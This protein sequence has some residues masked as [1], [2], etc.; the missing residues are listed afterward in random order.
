LYAKI[1]AWR[2]FCAAVYVAFLFGLRLYGAP[3][4]IRVV[5]ALNP[6]LML[7]FV[8]NAHN[9]LLAIAVLVYAAAAMRRGNALGYAGSLAL[10]GVAGLIKLPYA[11]L[12]LPILAAIRPMWSRISGAAVMVAAVVGLSWLW[13]GAQYFSTLFGHVTARPEDVVHRIAGI[14]AL[15][16]L[17]TAFFG[18]RRLRT[19]VWIL[20]MLAASVFS[21]Y[22]AWGTPYALARRRVLGYLLICFP[23][24]TILFDSAFERFWELLAVLPIVV[25]ISM[26]APEKP[27]ARVV[28]A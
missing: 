15:L 18:R 10:I 22:F 13:G 9:D 3:E 12:G 27:A 8:A 17:A 11:V 21:W 14:V 26:F 16:V 24:V 1:M 2:V 25:L 6:G 20:P 7:Q 4:R 23:F 28:T 19:A 5:A